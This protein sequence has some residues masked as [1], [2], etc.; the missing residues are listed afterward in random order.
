VA[1]AGWHR[2]GDA[3]RLDARGRLWL[4]GRCSARIVD[5]RGVVYPLSVE[6]GAQSHPSVRRAALVPH[7]GRRVLA[8]E[9]YR[10]AR[11]TDIRERLCS[12][13]IDEVRI[14]DR[15]PVDARHQSKVDYAALGRLLERQA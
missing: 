5:A 2:T 15:V 10:D 3:G 1:G 11:V 6:A 8:V 13:A 4:L 7:R 9:L 12:P 14:L